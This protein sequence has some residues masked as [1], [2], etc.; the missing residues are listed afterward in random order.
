MIRF[1]FSLLLVLFLTRATMAQQKRLPIDYPDTSIRYSL[2]Y[3]GLD[4]LTQGKLIAY[5]A[6]DSSKK[7]IEKNFYNGKISGVYRSYFPNG[8]THV[9]K[10]YQFGKQNGDWARYDSTGRLLEKARYEDGLL[11]GFYINKEKRMQ[12][13]YK[14]GIQNGKWEY[15]VGTTGYYRR[16]YENGVSIDQ[17]SLFNRLNIFKEGEEGT[18][19][20]QPNSV[21]TPKPSIDEKAQEKDSLLIVALQDTFLYAIRHLSRDSIGHPTMRKAVFKDHPQQVAV[22]KYIYK[23]QLNG[24]YKEYF[25]NGQL[26]VYANYSF[27]QLDGK[28][29]SYASNG[30]LLSKGNYLRGQRNGKWFIRNE[31]GVLKDMRY[32]KGELK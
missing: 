17:P 22:I 32:K 5:Y 26:H 1:S 10:V 9:F 29:S 8:K 15:N 16:Y 20:A 24:L 2:L 30:V 7:A 25:P 18:S 11:N 23:G 21:G 12:G 19:T 6:F 28:Y 13:R 31:K 4:S 3:K 14:A 27:G